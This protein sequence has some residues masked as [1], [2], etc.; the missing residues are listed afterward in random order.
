MTSVVR[1]AVFTCDSRH[2]AF[3]WVNQWDNDFAFLNKKIRGVKLEPVDGRDYRF[4][5]EDVR[6]AVDQPPLILG[7]KNTSLSRKYRVFNNKIFLSLKT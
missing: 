5:P 4:D 6:Q 3:F 7:N 2:S 1:Q